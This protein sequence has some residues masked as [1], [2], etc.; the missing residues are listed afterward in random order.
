MFKCFF[1]N[2]KARVSLLAYRERWKDNVK[3]Y[4]NHSVR[5]GTEMATEKGRNWE[6]ESHPCI[7]SPAPT[8]SAVSDEAQLPGGAEL[9]VQT[10]VVG[11][12]FP[13]P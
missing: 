1:G 7:Q 11:E 4:K 12:G 5:A 6:P 13:D 10:E 3:V 9:R 2:F 8:R